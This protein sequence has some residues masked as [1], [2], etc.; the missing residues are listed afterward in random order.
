M[1][2]AKIVE[3]EQLTRSTA[4]VTYELN[5][6]D[7]TIKR[8]VKVVE[9]MYS[10]EMAEDHCKKAEAKTN[11]FNKAMA[12]ILELLDGLAVDKVQ[13]EVNELESVKDSDLDDSYDFRK[14]LH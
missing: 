11:E 8:D 6:S 10:R 9:G 12:P 1:F 7:G 3:Y 14:G 13:Q 4:R 2:R 5:H